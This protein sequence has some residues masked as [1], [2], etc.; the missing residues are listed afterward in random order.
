LA[1]GYINM[2][3][4]WFQWG[5]AIII[6]GGLSAGSSLA[7]VVPPYEVRTFLDSAT[8][9]TYQFRQSQIKSR[10]VCPVCSF[11]SPVAGNCT[12]PWHVHSSQTVALQ[13]RNSSRLQRLLA[14][15][16]PDMAASYRDF[17]EYGAGGALYG[18]AVLGRPFLPSDVTRLGAPDWRRSTVHAKVANVNGNLPLSGAD[19]YRFQIVPPTPQRSDLGTSAL[20]ARRPMAAIDSDP[21]RRLEFRELGPGASTIPS[22]EIDDF[23]LVTV[24][25]YRVDEGDRWWIRYTELASS[26]PPLVN[27]VRIEAYSVLY[28]LDLDITIDP[29]G[30]QPVYF[31]F[32]VVSDSGALTITICPLAQVGGPECFHPDI[33]WVSNNEAVWVADF[34]VRSNCRLMPGWPDL[35]NSND[36]GFVDLAGGAHGNSSFDL[37]NGA[38]PAAKACYFEDSGSTPAVTTESVVKETNAAA[39][40]YVLPNN[41][42]GL[43]EIN[44]QYAKAPAVDWSPALDGVYTSF[45]VFR[46]A[47]GEWQYDERELVTNE[48]LANRTDSFT[49]TRGVQPIS[50]RFMV[51]RVDIPPTGTVWNHGTVDEVAEPVPSVIAYPRIVVGYEVGNVIGGA[52]APGSVTP[53]R[54]FRTYNRWRASEDTRACRVCGYV[55]GPD[56]TAPA[57]CPY[58]E[59][60]TLVTR[61]TPVDGGA[62]T[63]YHQNW[64]TPSVVAQD[65]RFATAA[66]RTFTIPWT[67]LE[68]GQTWVGPAY[69]LGGAYNQT[70][71]VR[72]PRYQAPSVPAPTTGPNAASDPNSD[73]GYRGSSVL[74]RPTSAV[75]ASAGMTGDW[76][77]FFRCPD[78]GEFV[79]S[80]NGAGDPQHN[81]GQAHQYCAICG[82]E[83]PRSLGL[84]Y[85]P[86]DRRELSDFD[87]NF[88]CRQEHLQAEEYDVFDVQVSVNRKLEVAPTLASTQVGRVAPGVPAFQPDIT[89]GPLANH[90]AFPADVS[91]LGALLLKNEGNVGTPVRIANVYDGS[92]GSVDDRALEHYR[93]VEL[94]PSSLSYGRL[95]QSNPITRDLFTPYDPTGT[96]SRDW[97]LRPQGVGGAAGVETIG[98]VTAGRYGAAAKPLPLGQAVGSYV[99]QHLHYVDAN[100]NGVLDFYSLASGS[101]TNSGVTQF[102]PAVDLPYEPVVAVINGEMRV[103]ESRLPQNDYYS[104]DTSPVATVEPNTGAGA[105]AVQLMW[106]ATR[107]SAV[108]APVGDDAPGGLDDSAIPVSN[109]TQNLLTLRLPGAALTADDPLYRPYYIPTSGGTLQLPRVLTGNGVGAVNSAPWVMWNYAGNARW[110]FWHRNIRHAGGVESTLR[111]DSTTSWNWSGSGESEFIYSTGLPKQNLRGFATSGGAWLFWHSGPTGREQLY[112]RWNFD[113]TVSNREGPV[114]ISNQVAPGQGNEVIQAPIEA[115]GTDY[116]PIRR[117]S[118]TPFTYTRTPSAFAYG[119]VVNLMFSGFVQS[120]QQADICWERFNLNDMA[121]GGAANPGPNYGKLPF[122][123][124]ENWEELR[125]DGLRQNFSSRHLDWLVS[126]DF[127]TSP[128]HGPD[129]ALRLG[130]VFD[131]WGDAEAPVVRTF[132][133]SW[134]GGTYL[135][136]RGTYRVTPV[137]TGLG[138]A[139]FVSGSP[140]VIEVGSGQWQLRDPHSSVANPRPVTMEIDIASGVVQFS[141]PLFNADAPGDTLAVFNTGLKDA[142]IGKSLADVIV[143]GNYT[144]YVYRVTRSGAHDDSPSAFYDPG[145]ASR[146]TV[147]W[148]RNHS[149]SELPFMGRSAFMY[150]VY[151]T[152]VQMGRP[153]VSGTPVFTDI[154]NGN[155]VSPTDSDPASGIYTFGADLIG[156]TLG[157][158]YN[159][160]GVSSQAER[161]RV[162]GWSTENLVPVDTV[163]GEGS[164]SVVPE[165]YMVPASDGGGGSANVPAVRYWLFWASPRGVWDL[166]LVEDGANT[167][168]AGDLP[169]H[170]SADIYTAVVAPEYGTLRPE[171]NL[172][173]VT[174]DP[175]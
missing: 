168:Q 146:L 56:Q 123:R 7:Q 114:A 127:A 59:G 17:V 37:I 152:S 91:P 117:P 111:Y 116:R 143:R 142:A 112:Y 98:Y 51:S 141:S 20:S 115:N 19:R 102:N 46:R 93:R 45:Q 67:A 25:P 6:L 35:V 81:C 158:T 96:M 167:R 57:R 62:Y 156:R 55:W 162:I 97:S 134:S 36:P 47:D 44:L 86:F 8:D 24:N 52:F 136:A 42:V 39:I 26:L 172:S 11:S 95:A 66:Q 27:R 133:I 34:M 100:N 70:M 120:E 40:P 75:G 22:A 132:G 145:A 154:G 155:S 29:Q 84:I 170:P 118:R 85:C 129:P 30:N 31:P 105:G 153:P 61:I 126:P 33:G 122:P 99:G 174:I 149:S 41:L 4:S 14:V 12:D 140:Y 60:N 109:P 79:N 101:D 106:A 87:A 113:G 38:F 119:G 3:R 49:A 131:E 124:V 107:P 175:T 171:M 58:H 166:R 147:F 92:G 71:Q 165:S 108:G 110:A 50:S 137:L 73:R 88:T 130:L 23:I 104:A 77:S 89:V 63:A 163:V 128:G 157:V 148:R 21:A 74:Y 5:L 169:I 43:G 160:A 69:D 13:D 18:R 173:S 103:F 76:D 150:K 78:C 65:E 64:R 90:K 10:Y 135:R 48:K 164:F 15:A 72:L 151:T 32:T 80:L 159:G 16:A 9:D 2:K 138:G 54:S 1:K 121:P 28:G 125:S 83:F 94:N 144:A 68:P 139:S 53:L 161:H 82:S